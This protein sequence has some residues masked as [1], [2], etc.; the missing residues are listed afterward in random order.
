MPDPTE[1][2]R[3]AY[4]Q[5]LRDWFAKINPISD[6]L[7]A[8]TDPKCRKAA[9]T[10]LLVALGAFDGAVRRLAVPAAYLSDWTALERTD[11]AYEVQLIQ[12]FQ[13]SEGLANL[14]ASADEYTAARDLARDL[15]IAGY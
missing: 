15:G 1:G 12:G 4:S 6:Q 2:A 7:E 13:T 5:P 8:C 14:S 10:D 9:L 11:Y 3:A